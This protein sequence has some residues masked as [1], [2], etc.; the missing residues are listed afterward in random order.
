VI[1]SIAHFIIL[2]MKSWRI[3]TMRR[4]TKPATI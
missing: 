3:S 2:G 1:A 4:E